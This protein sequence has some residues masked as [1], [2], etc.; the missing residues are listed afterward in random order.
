MKWTASEFKGEKECL[1]SGTNDL[2][3]QRD[4]LYIL[5]NVV[6]FIAINII[7]KVVIR[8]KL[9]HLSPEGTLESSKRT[10]WEISGNIWRAIYA[11]VCIRDSIAECGTCLLYM[12]KERKPQIWNNKLL[13]SGKGRWKVSWKLELHAYKQF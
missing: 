4:S 13:L 7:W 8:I 3:L 12:G 9:A 5:E 1:L 10:S 6:I 2:L 11:F